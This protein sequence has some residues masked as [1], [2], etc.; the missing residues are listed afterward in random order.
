M[1][2]LGFIALQVLAT[3]PNCGF[4]GRGAARAVACHGLRIYVHFIDASHRS[5][6]VLVKEQSQAPIAKTESIIDLDHMIFACQRVRNA[7]CA[8]H[9]LLISLV[10]WSGATSYLIIH[11]WLYAMSQ[12]A[13]PLINFPQSRPSGTL[14]STAKPT[15]L[16]DPSQAGLLLAPSLCLSPAFPLASPLIGLDSPVDTIPLETLA[17]SYPVVAQLVQ[18]R[19]ELSQQIM[20]STSQFQNL[21]DETSRL[22]ERIALLER[23]YVA[24]LQLRPSPNLRTEHVNTAHHFRRPLLTC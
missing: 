5:L 2:Q 12:H 24:S 7:C 8:T 3:S 4:L 19:N 18:Q 6:V 15:L 17:A 14:D 20:R 21:Y 13:V 16:Q 10:I 1:V 11:T 23:G 22:R 9:L